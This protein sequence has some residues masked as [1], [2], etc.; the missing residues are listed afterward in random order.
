M[1]N[2]LVAFLVFLCPLL[3]S[4]EGR[5]D[6]PLKGAYLGVSLGKTSRGLVVLRVEESSAA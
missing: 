2:I 5:F 1:R 4:D 3:R 6:P